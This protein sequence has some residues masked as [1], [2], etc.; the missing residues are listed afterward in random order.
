M[1]K[2]FTYTFCALA[3][4]VLILAGSVQAPGWETLREMMNFNK[5]TLTEQLSRAREA[6]QAEKIL[7]RFKE[8]ENTKIGDFRVSEL[9]SLKT[10]CELKDS[11]DPNFLIKPQDESLN[12]NYGAV[13]FVSARI[14]ERRRSCT[15]RVV[16]LLEKIALPIRN[17]EI[18][19]KFYSKL[20][21]PFATHEAEYALSKYIP[22]MAWRQRKNDM[23]RELFSSCVQ[24]IEKLS[25][26]EWCSQLKYLDSNHKLIEHWYFRMQICRRHLD[27]QC[28]GGKRGLSYWSKSDERAKFDAECQVKEKC[29][30]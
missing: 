4:S 17:K 16:P 29:K 15:K 20:K 7:R 2:E 30:A 5:P 28:S 21:T 23:L 22:K 24:L 12:R 18:V 10:S 13:V 19:D 9:L 1:A 11:S 27:S 14:D 26:L 6:E 25:T 8:P 3:C